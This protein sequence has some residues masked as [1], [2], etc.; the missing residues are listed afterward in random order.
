MT[1]SPSRGRHP[2]MVDRR[3]DCGYALPNRGPAR[4]R[5]EVGC[6]Q[7]ITKNST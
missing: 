6:L 7:H 4:F 3:V 2:T 5:K 1:G